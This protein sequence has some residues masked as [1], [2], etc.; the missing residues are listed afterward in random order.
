MNPLN[1]G[2]SV[3]AVIVT[4]ALIIV[5]LLIGGVI[6]KTTADVYSQL[7]INGTWAQLRETTVNY[8]QQGI[9]IMLI[10]IILTA[11]GVV[12]AVIFGFMGIVGGR[13]RA[14]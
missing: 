7:N 6:D 14:E 5:G 9:N 10:A 8:A 4:I 3:L 11:L 12:L 1:V 13:A 2:Y